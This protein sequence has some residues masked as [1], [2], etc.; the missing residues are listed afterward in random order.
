MSGEVPVALRL[1]REDPQDVAALQRVLEAAPSYYHRVTGGPPTPQEA[2]STYRILPE[3][4]SPQDKFL[5]GIVRGDELVGCVDLVRGYPKPEIAYLGL[6]L[7]SERQQ[8][9]GIG[10]AAYRLVEETV[11]GWGACDRIRLSVLRANDGV[12]PFWA[13]FG[14]VP[15]GEVRPYRAGTVTSE[16]LLFEKPLF[17]VP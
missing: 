16:A 14:F 3:G 9:R 12:I 2:R 7:V 13:S 15:T 5:F 17:V 8:K 4:K 11:L 1:L 6:L 10:R